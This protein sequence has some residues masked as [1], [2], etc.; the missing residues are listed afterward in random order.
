[1]RIRSET[2]VRTE[3]ILKGHELEEQRVVVHERYPTSAS[4]VGYYFLT[5]GNFSF[6][7]AAA[8]AWDGSPTPARVPQPVCYIVEST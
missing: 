6:A 3:L 1:M 2:V 5:S 8:T 7:A 4:M